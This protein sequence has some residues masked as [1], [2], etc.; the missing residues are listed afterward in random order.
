MKAIYFCKGSRARAL[1]HAS[2]HRL[3]FQLESMGGT[4][5]TQALVISQLLLVVLSEYQRTET[6]HDQKVVKW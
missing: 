1:I 2:I 5:V 3:Y 4:L 6:Y